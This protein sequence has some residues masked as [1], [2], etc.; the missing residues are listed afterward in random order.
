[1]V[2]SSFVF[3]LLL[4]LHRLLRKLSACLAAKCS[5]GAGVEQQ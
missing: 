2:Q 5:T 3:E 1:M 4:G